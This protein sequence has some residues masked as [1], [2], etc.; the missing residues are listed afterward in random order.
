MV[1]TPDP[2]TA[3]RSGSPAPGNEAASAER[4]GMTRQG[5]VTGVD[6]ART[7]VAETQEG[8][9]RRSGPESHRK[10]ARTIAA[11]AAA[12]VPRPG[13]R[14]PLPLSL[15]LPTGETGTSCSPQRRAAAISRPRRA[16]PAAC[17]VRR[18]GPG[19]LLLI[20]LV[21]PPGRA[22]QPAHPVPGEAD[23]PLV[24]PLPAP[25]D[26]A[27]QPLEFRSIERGT[28]YELERDPDG[29]PAYRAISRCGASAMLLPL[30]VDFDPLRTPRLAWRWRIERG[31]SID[32]EKAGGTD[33]FA[34]RVY[35]L[36]RFDPE[37]ASAWRR[38]QQRIG[39]RLFGA[40]APGR[41]LSYVWSS[42][43]PVGASWPSPRQPEA[44]RLVV[45]ETG[46]DR[47]AARAW[48]EEIVDL[49]A[50]AE[51]FFSPSPRQP[52]Y[53]LGLM[54]DADDVC[55][56]AVAWYSDFRLLG[57]GSKP[58]GDARDGGDA[59]PSGGGRSPDPPGSAGEARLKR[60]AG[61]ATHPR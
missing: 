17:V 23:P 39:R 6:A 53:A 45:L 40:E 9:T 10:S 59:G 2:E 3:R 50:D 21:C 7:L 49:Q 16:D 15:D 14:T 58:S 60:D 19:L 47:T 4:P 24:I 13:V 55:R 32:D 30:P 35:V 57:P 34:A 33:D 38:L 54:T 26:P 36:Y 48:R 25:G 52:A 41:T 56:E 22:A 29:R 51:R 5:R 31:L 46:S 1:P 20:A 12:R 27:W 18:I 11:P 8:S 28:L 37:R 43:S 61:R 42:R 44:A